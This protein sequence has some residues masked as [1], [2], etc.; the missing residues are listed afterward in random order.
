MYVTVE[1]K[2]IVEGRTGVALVTFGTVH[3]LTETIKKLNL[4]IIRLDGKIM[5]L[6]LTKLL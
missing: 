5:F 1:L 4:I 6:L 3:V 2:S